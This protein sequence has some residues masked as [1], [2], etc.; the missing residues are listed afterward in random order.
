MQAPSCFGKAACLERRGIQLQICQVTMFFVGLEAARSH[1]L[2][3]YTTLSCRLAGLDLQVVTLHRVKTNRRNADVH[4]QTPLTKF[5]PGLSCVRMGK[6]SCSPFENE[7]RIF[8]CTSCLL[9]SAQGAPT[10]GDAGGD[11]GEEPEGF[12]EDGEG[13]P[14]KQGHLCPSCLVRCPSARLRGESPLSSASELK[15]R[16]RRI[17]RE[18]ASQPDDAL[19]KQLKERPRTSPLR[20]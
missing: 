20:L 19:R 11:A 12:L 18:E 9:C 7:C 6:K 17:S 8:R 10:G 1:A 3:S 13:P 4:H 5:A 14:G 15:K 16:R 2:R